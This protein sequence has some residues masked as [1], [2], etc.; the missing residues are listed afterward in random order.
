GDNVLYPSAAIGDAALVKRLFALGAKLRDTGCS[1]PALTEA[2][3]DGQTDIVQILLEHGARIDPKDGD[4]GNATT[5]LMEAAR[6]GHV[7]IVN[8]LLAHGANPKIETGG[9]TALSV[10]AEQGHRSIVKTLL[11]HPAIIAEAPDVYDHALTSAIE[12]KHP[13]IVRELIC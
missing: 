3:K 6:N 5:P 8:I 12:G 2:A 9:N 11:I 4:N 1:D 13:L 10:A 7:T